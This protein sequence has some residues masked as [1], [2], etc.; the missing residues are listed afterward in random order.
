MKLETKATIA[1]VVAMIAAASTITL[2]AL[3]LSV[4][5][6][7]INSLNDM[8]DSLR[9]SV[10]ALADAVFV[11]R[12]PGSIVDLTSSSIQRI[13]NAFLVSDL[14]MEKHL[15]GLKVS[16]RV[17]NVQAVRHTNAQFT[18]SIDK[19][20]KDFEINMISPGNST[21][22]SVY[23]PDIPENTKLATIEYKQSIIGYH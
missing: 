3:F 1:V 15:S 17:I 11:L 7:R 18:L 6:N 16:G 23:I 19:Q 12:L 20:K 5:A 22:F 14:S 9:A 10:D 2:G 8:H 13:D 21:V 4:F